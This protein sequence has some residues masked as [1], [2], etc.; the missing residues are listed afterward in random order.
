MRVKVGG[1]RLHLWRCCCGAQEGPK[2]KDTEAM[3]KG[4]ERKEPK[5]KSSKENYSEQSEPA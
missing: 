5:R 3:E 2:P 1:N 4:P